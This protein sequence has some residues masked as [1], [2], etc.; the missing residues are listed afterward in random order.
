MERINYPSI[1]IILFFISAFLI[2]L[3]LIPKYQMVS[4]LKNSLSDYKKALTEQKEYFENVDKD[5]EKLK[6]YEDLTKKI[7]LAIPKESS[8]VDFFN[9]IDN[10]ASANGPFLKGV[11]TFSISESKEIS[12]IKETEISFNVSGPYPFFKNFISALEKSARMIKIENISFKSE[13]QPGKEK[14]EGIF[15]FSLKVKAYSF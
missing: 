5:L 1:A 15:D 6:E 11:G 3:F 10:L 4:K 7:S 14:T 8:I 2:S 9:L 13:A 12:G